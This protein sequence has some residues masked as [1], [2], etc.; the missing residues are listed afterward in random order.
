MKTRMP[1]TVKTRALTIFAIGIRFISFPSRVVVIP[2]VNGTIRAWI[3]S[4]RFWNILQL[5]HG[6]HAPA[7]ILRETYTA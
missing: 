5:A 7:A 1:R 6:I 2:A 3:V 4:H